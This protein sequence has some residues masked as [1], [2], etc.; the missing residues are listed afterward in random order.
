MRDWVWGE[1]YQNDI[2]PNHEGEG[3]GESYSRM[4]FLQIMRDRSVVRAIPGWYFSKS[5]ERGVWWEL[6]QC[7]ISPNRW[8]ERCRESDRIVIRCYIYHHYNRC[9]ISLK[10]VRWLPLVVRYTQCN[11]LWTSYHWLITSRW[12]YPVPRVSCT[13][14]T[15]KSFSRITQLIFICVKYLL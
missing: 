15:G 7:V 6:F 11:F 12:I 8:R 5:W 4:I 14:K 13:R 3:C 9:L 2:S 10:F 1:L